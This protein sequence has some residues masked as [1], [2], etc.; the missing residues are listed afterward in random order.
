MSFTISA[1]NAEEENALTIVKVN[2]ENIAQKGRISVQKTGD[3]FVSV[4]AASSAYTDEN[5]E[6]IVNPTIYTPCLRTEILPVRS[7]FQVIA[8]EDI[9]TLDAQFVP[10]QGM[11]WLS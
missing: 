8:S 5:G 9:V 4:A 1:E 2:K 6:M 3:S 11:L 7:V 10:M